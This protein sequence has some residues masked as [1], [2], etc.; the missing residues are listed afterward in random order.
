MFKKYKNLKLFYWV[1]TTTRFSS[2]F[3]KHSWTSV[4][5]KVSKATRFTNCVKKKS[6]ITS[7]RLMIRSFDR[8][9]VGVNPRAS[10]WKDKI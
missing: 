6:K 3:L 8:D 4:K 10:S 2:K 1:N 7:K 5:K 9:A